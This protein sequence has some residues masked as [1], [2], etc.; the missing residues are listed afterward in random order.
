MEEEEKE[1]ESELEGMAPPKRCKFARETALSV[2]PIRVLKGL[3]GPTHITS[4][5]VIRC[6]GWPDDNQ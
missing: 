5:P 2:S 3:E 6:F 1:G 4:T